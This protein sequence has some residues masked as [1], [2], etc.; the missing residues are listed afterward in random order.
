MV[1]RPVILPETFSG[2]G[3]WEQWVYHFE[4]VAAVNAWT[5][6]NK[7]L[8]LKIRLTGRAQ[9]A[10]QRLSPEARGNYTEA[11]KGLMEPFEPA[12][13]RD[14]YPAEFK[15]RSKKTS[16]GWAAYAEDLKALVEKAFP[17]MGED[18]R[19]QLALTKYM[20]QLDH[21]QVTFAVNSRNLKAGMPP[22]VPL[23]K[24]RATQQ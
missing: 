2:T 1:T 3:S 16:D 5:E 12:S 11:K 15:T 23:W 19:E 10:F 17:D 24:W 13:R 14:L 7:L 9:T 6:Q 21:P 8:W 18:G 20:S 4:N 22:S